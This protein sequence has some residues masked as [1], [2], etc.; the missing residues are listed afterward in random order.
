MIILQQPH[1]NET[2]MCTRTSAQIIHNRLPV[3]YDVLRKSQKVY[4]SSAKQEADV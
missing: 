1:R 3:I 2:S 4:N